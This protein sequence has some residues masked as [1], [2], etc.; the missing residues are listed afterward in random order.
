M[1]QSTTGVVIKD[2][3]VSVS[4]LFPTRENSVFLLSFSFYVFFCFYL[5]L[6]TVYR[7]VH[8]RLVYEA[9]WESSTELPEP[10]HTGQW[11]WNVVIVNGPPMRTRALGTSDLR[12]EKKLRCFL[13]CGAEQ[14]LLDCDFFCIPPFFQ[15]HAWTSICVFLRETNC[16]KITTIRCS[17]S[18]ITGI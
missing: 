2:P 11:R 17:L 16:N 8:E 14:A 9:Q 18:I 6:L 5:F 7:N 1:R 12:V 4:A 3:F 10:K 15:G 13:F